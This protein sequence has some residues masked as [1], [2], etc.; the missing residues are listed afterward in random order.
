MAFKDYYQIM[1]VARDATEQEIKKAYKRLARKYHPD[2][3]K[4]A[5][6]ETRFKEL[7][8]AYDVLRDPKKRQAYDLYGADWQTARQAHSNGFAG[9]QYE[10]AAP[11]MHQFEDIF[12]S[13]FGGQGFGGNRGGRRG[14]ESFDLHGDHVRAKIQ[15]DLADS[16]HGATRTLTLNDGQGQPKTLN[17]RIPKG[18]VAGQY[19]RLAGQGAAGLGSGK[20][21]DLLLEVAFKPH[22]MYRVEG[23]DV[24]LTLPVAPWEAALGASV[25]VP[26]PNGNIDLKIPANSANGRRL[27]LVGKGLPAKQ[28][29]DFYV[30]LH[31]VL[32]PATSQQAKQAY[33]ALKAATDFNPRRHWGKA[34]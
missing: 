3:N 30:E 6:A 22:A 34:S 5:D 8:E 31:V 25:S 23:K 14:F 33:E 19:I 29:G 27:R 2:V 4:A 21:G 16:Y 28:P 15:I 1:G 9:Q 17:V 7:G 11:D 13:F 26:L 18:V 12:S 32:P 24:Y 20:A 10:Q